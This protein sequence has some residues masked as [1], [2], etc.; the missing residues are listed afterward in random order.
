M[1][2]LDIKTDKD[3]QTYLGITEKRFRF[4]KFGK[5]SKKYFTFNIPKHG[6]GFRTICSP[7]PSL[8]AVHNKLKVEFDKLCYTCESV[9]G[10]TEGRSIKTN[11]DAHKGKRIVINID[12]ENFFESI[13]IGRLIGLFQ[14]KPFCFPR[15]VAV[16][17]SQ[18]LCF[19]R[20][21]AQGSPCSPVL[22][23]MIFFKTD[24]AIFKYIK[25]KSIHYTRYA[26]DIT[27]SFNKKNYI[28][29]F[30][31]EDKELNKDFAKIFKQSK[32]TINGRKTRIQ[33]SHMHQQVTGIKVN[34]AD[35]LSL[36][37]G[38]KYKIR[39][40]LHALEKFGIENAAKE[41]ALR[42]GIQYNQHTSVQLRDL[43][44]GEIAYFGMIRGTTS[45]DYYR[46]ASSFNNIFGKNMISVASDSIDIIKNNSVLFVE[47][48]NIFYGTAFFYKGFVVTCIHCIQEKAKVGDVLFF[49][50]ASRGDKSKKCASVISTDGL[51][52]IAIL[53]CLSSTSLVNIPS[54]SKQASIGDEV[55]AL[56]YPDFSEDSE[57]RL[58]DLRGRITTKRKYEGME[59]FVT[60]MLMQTGISGG[61]ILN[62]K[63]ELIGMA[64]LGND[65]LMV[66]EIQNGFVPAEYIDALIS[67][68]NDNS[69]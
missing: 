30:C 1:N 18:I 12:L 44:R 27:F 50:N 7:T 46:F 68:Y 40:L 57:F 37:R 66:S 58:A 21:L 15:E 64:C 67:N 25:G 33:L 62:N 5:P 51:H 38:F 19:E 8:K 22:S 10:F 4:F 69:K 20:H 65:K 9:H 49:S 59:I 54:A 43:L 24:K 56:G 47:T 31:D 48:G 34:N 14:H 16:S 23:N 53:K 52:D 13:H 36:N 39:G 41:Y 3:L 42:C 55:S 6:G 29:L 35:H 26:D 32:F 63:N 28:K 60:D 61:P 17:L 2:F 11:A 45:I